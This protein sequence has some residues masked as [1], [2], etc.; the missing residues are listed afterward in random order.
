MS[1]VLSP[2]VRK[3]LS[4]NEW[5]WQILKIGNVFGPTFGFKIISIQ[6]IKNRKNSSPHDFY[7][8]TREI[9]AS[10][11]TSPDL[12]QNLSSDCLWAPLLYRIRCTLPIRTRLLRAIL[13]P[14]SSAWRS[15]SVRAEVGK[16]EWVDCPVWIVNLQQL[17][18]RHSRHTSTAE[19]SVSKCY[20]D[21]F[22]AS[23]FGS[24]S[25]SFLSISS[26]RLPLSCF[27]II[28]SYHQDNE[29]ILC[30]YSSLHLWRN[31]VLMSSDRHRVLQRCCATRVR[32]Y[33]HGLL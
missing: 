9:S 5:S 15:V 31:V 33:F 21:R 11:K 17:S 24:L 13:K 28:S 23:Y 26:Y 25:A 20:E 12:A 7:L 32:R 27:A 1:L 16:Q 22:T 18:A 19:G 30:T 3:N 6:G 2:K 29:D 14:R 10:P 4:H 8:P